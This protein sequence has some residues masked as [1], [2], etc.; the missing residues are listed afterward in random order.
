[1]FIR[2]V[3]LVVLCTIMYAIGAVWLVGGAVFDWTFGMAFSLWGFMR[4]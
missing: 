3:A 2:L 1:M 4:G